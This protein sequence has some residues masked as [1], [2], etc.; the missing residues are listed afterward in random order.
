MTFSSFTVWSQ[1]H[2][3]CHLQNV[4]FLS[5][6]WVFTIKWSIHAI[7]W[8]LSLDRLELSRS[9]AHYIRSVLSQASHCSTAIGFPPH[10]FA[11]TLVAK[12]CW[13]PQVKVSHVT[14]LYFT[15][16]V[17]FCLFIFFFS[18]LF[19]PGKLGC[20]TL[21]CYSSGFLMPLHFAVGWLA[22][23]AHL[24]TK[25][26]TLCCMSWKFKWDK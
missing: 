16:Y 9:T 7:K 21:H 10:I 12:L 8:N 24:A 6:T 14:L 3:Q 18:G 17:F 2:V 20:L 13:K 25:K 15:G 4:H 22:I 11:Q 19:G 1:G 26:Q 5:G 23:T